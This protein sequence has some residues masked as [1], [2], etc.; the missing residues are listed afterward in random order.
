[1]VVERQTGEVIGTIGIPREN[2]I[3]YGLKQTHWGKGYA[4]EA[5]AV[6][7]QT[8]FDKLSPEVEEWRAYSDVENEASGKVLSKVGFR[9]LGGDP[10]VFENPSLGT[11]Y[12]RSWGLKR[13][14]LI[15]PSQLKS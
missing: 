5:L 13:E 15:M 4:T 11:R 12:Q 6:F 14:D 1:M 10:I 3:G 8:L 7:M 2:E 9:D